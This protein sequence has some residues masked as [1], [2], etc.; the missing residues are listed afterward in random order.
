MKRTKVGSARQQ[1]ASHAGLK[2]APK[3][4][5]RSAKR[6]KLAEIADSDNDN[7]DKDLGGLYGSRESSPTRRPQS[8]GR[9]PIGDPSGDVSLDNDMD[10]RS[11]RPT[12]IESSL[13]AIISDEEAIEQ[14][15]SFKASQGEAGTDEP[16][17][18]ASRLDSRKWIRGKSSLYVDAFN[19]AL[20]TVLDE[21]SH[22]FNAR[23]SAV[24]E[25]WRALPYESQFLYVA[26]QHSDPW[27]ICKLTRVQICSALPEKECPVA[28]HVQTRLPFRYTRCR[29]CC[30][31]SAA[32][33]RSACA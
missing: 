22:L 30:T 5:R 21:E 29:R 18:A 15:E 23:E 33:S 12:A 6:I 27:D 25:K 17:S 16:D 11:H 7:D 10:D 8:C 32:S 19:L 3:S 24:F 13:P 14:Y 20:D 1:P 28:P 2:D 26:I 4:P 31:R 9:L